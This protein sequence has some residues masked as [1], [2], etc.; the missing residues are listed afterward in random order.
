M[1]IRKQILFCF[2]M[3]APFGLAAEGCSGREDPGQHPPAESANSATAAVQEPETPLLQAGPDSGS[4]NSRPGTQ[5]GR[6]TAE[7]H[8]HHECACTAEQWAQAKAELAALQSQ[9]QA[10]HGQPTGGTGEDQATRRLLEQLQRAR[11]AAAEAQAALVELQRTNEEQRKQLELVR[12]ELA[13]L[14]KESGTS[15]LITKAR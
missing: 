1:R 15:W 14:Q 8:M 4:P 10:A 7:A 2:F 13:Q 3:A 11:S 6:D 5:N 9:L 12:Q